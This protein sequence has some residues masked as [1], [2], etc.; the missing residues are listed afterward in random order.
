MP[1]SEDYKTWRVYLDTMK[2]HVK[3]IDMCLD[4]L[5]GLYKERK[6]KK[7]PLLK[8]KRIDYFEDELYEAEIDYVFTEEKLKNLEKRLS[9]RR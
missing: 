9:I 5:S 2:M 8:E 6:K 7:L 1:T 4:E 3:I